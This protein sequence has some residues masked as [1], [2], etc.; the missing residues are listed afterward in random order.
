[1]KKF[2]HENGIWVL[3]AALLLTAAVTMTSALVPNFTSPL[4]NVI[5]IVSSPFQGVTSAFTNWVEGLYNYAF[6]YDQMAARVE[7]LE[8]EV[9]DVR[10]EL[11]KAQDAQAENEAL[12]EALGLVK[13]NTDLTL[14]DVTVTGG[15]STS[16]ESTMTLSKGSNAGIAVG[17][18]VIT[19]TGYLIG[20]VE[21]VG[22]N[23]SQIITIIDPN[24]KISSVVYRTGDT[25]MLESDLAM[26]EEGKCMLTYLGAD[27]TFIPGDEVLTSGENGTYPSG[28]VV[29]HV[30]SV[31]T[32]P[33]GLEKY[34]EVT[35]AA[36]LDDLGTIFVI[37][38]FSNP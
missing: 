1:M 4:S 24:I 22:T 34:A 16:W 17:D 12:R 15:S 28:L 6:R 19:G 27:V 11:R 14:L 3:I 21:Q 25:V 7:E 33:S 31:Q 2:F 13:E 30:D 23:W 38:D 20:V 29:G 18:C 37:T 35:P 26:M 36:N 10:A 9:S 32:K 8:Q 5:G